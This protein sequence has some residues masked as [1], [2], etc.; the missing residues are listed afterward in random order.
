MKT[1]I[2]IALASA[3]LVAGLAVAGS[4]PAAAQVA[5]SGS[6]PLPHGRISIGIGSPAFAVGS[7]VPYGYTVIQD[8]TYGY[9]FYYGS[10]W[11]PAQPYGSG[12][13]VVSQ[14]YYPGAY[15]QPYAYA[16][17]YYAHPYYA[18]PYYAHPYYA[19]SYDGYGH[20]DSHRSEGHS[21]HRS[22][23]NG[24]TRDRR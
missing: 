16:R 4:S 9:G 2:R 15:V 24:R 12:W 23:G 5:F 6:F 18:H 22:D 20:Y 13:I 11:I 19:H 8:P 21:D 1:R 3:V 10:S 17:P 14:P 7:P